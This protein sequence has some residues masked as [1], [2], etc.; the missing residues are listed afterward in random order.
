MTQ[1]RPDPGSLI[2]RLNSEQRRAERAQLKIFF[3]AAP[4]VGKTYSMLDAAQRMRASGLDV[5]VGWVETH[6]RPETAA[7]LAG[8]EQLR[9]REATYRGLEI[10]EFDVEAALTRRPALLLVDELAHTNVE[11]SRH[12]KRWQDVTELLDAGIDVW[13]TLNVQH[14][15]SLNDVVAQIT[16]VRV[17]ETVPDS[18]LDRADEVELVDLP[19]EALLERLRAGKVYLPEQAQRAVTRFFRKGNLLALRELALRRTAERVD[20]DVRAYRIEHG[21]AATWPAAERILVCIGPGPH[22]AEL[23][24]AACRMAAGLRADWTAVYVEIPAHARLPQEDRDWVAQHLRLAESLGGRVAMLSGERVSA[25]LLAY[26]RG[27]NVTKILLGKPTHAR[28]RDLLRGSL[29][30]EIIRDS[31][32]IDVY[33]SSGDPS[34]GP[35]HPPRT[36]SRRSPL[37]SYLWSLVAVAI[38]TGVAVL[39]YG[40][41][42]TPDL[43]LAYLLATVSV[44]VRFG[45]GPSA[46]TATAGVL[47]FD[48]FFVPPQFTFAVRDAHYLLSFAVMLIVGLTVSTLAAQVRERAELARSHALWA[49]TLHAV[50]RE[51]AQARDIGAIAAC[52]I[53]HV[54]TALIGVATLL[55]AGEG[56]VL[57]PVPGAGGFTPDADDGG[58]ARWV[59]EH[60]KPAGLGTDTLPGAVTLYL[61]LH[62]GAEAVGVLGFR[63]SDGRPLREASQREMLDAL[64]QQ[65]AGALERALLAEESKQI[66]LRARTEELRNTLLSSVSHDLR[67]PLAAIVG[68]ATTLLGEHGTLDAPQRTDLLRTIQ[69]EAEHLSR[70]VANLLA[71]TRLES[72]HLVVAKE[73]VPVEEVVGAALTRLGSRLGRRP[74]NVRIAREAGMAHVDPVLLEQAVVNLLE[75][76]VQHTPADTPVELAATADRAWLELEVLDRGPGLPGGF[77][78]RV[79]EKFVRGPNAAPGGSGLGLAICRGVAVAHGGTIGAENRV[80]G[81]AVVRLRLPVTGA[82]PSVPQEA[83]GSGRPSEA[84]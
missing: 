84:E 70:L 61:P 32:E 59:F 30:D 73:W 60:R 68:S 79:F 81:G 64:A 49:E 72:G 62:S 23:V 13:S 4:G 76:V 15:E 78:S 6:G 1:T 19:P 28:W 36:F 45:R 75:N 56:R 38:A 22:A 69:D 65:V 51:L 82:P 48:F 57:A 46:F 18:L 39:M 63:P 3:G 27:H 25:E 9:P 16:S 24:R 41:F 55:V 47:L 29:L 10:E 42:Q 35:Q 5:V 8:L 58:V 20:A 37:S 40:R 2:Q 7:L 67:T 21:I 17:R 80:G 34:E 50:S 74:V 11:G 33:V 43:M 53:R 52:S 12:R 44:A 83:D 71:M 31:G 26:A 77:E 14:L 54:E 66:E